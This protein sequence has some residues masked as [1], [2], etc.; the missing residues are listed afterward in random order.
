MKNTVR[1]C[2]PRGEI[3]MDEGHFTTED[4]TDEDEPLKKG[5]GSQ[6]KAKFCC[7]SVCS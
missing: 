5:V 6:R 4:R 1:G 2:S 7:F 3:E